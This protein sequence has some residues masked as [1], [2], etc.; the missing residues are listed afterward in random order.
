MI[1]FR[2]HVVSL[3]AVFLA[4]AIG[5]VVGTAALNG[6]L[7][8]DLKDKVNALSQQNQQYRAQV[9]QMEDQAGRNERSCGSTKRI[10]RIRWGALPISTSRSISDSRT[11]RNS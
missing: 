11:S 5:L 6:P 7:S 1:N 10:G 2:Y 8:E 3:T 4:L 9:K